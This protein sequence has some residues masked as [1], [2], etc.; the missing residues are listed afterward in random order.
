MFIEICPDWFQ[1]FNLAFQI[2]FL[3]VTASI[4]ITGYG[5]YKFFRQEEQLYLS[6][7]WG[8]IALSYIAS[9]ISQTAQLLTGYN[10]LMSATGLAHMYLFLAGITILLFVYLRIK[11]SGVRAVLFVLLLGLMAFFNQSDWSAKMPAFHLLLAVLM[12]FI[13]GQLTK[14]YRKTCSRARLLVTAGFALLTAG[15][16]LLITMHPIFFVLAMTLTLI[17]YVCIAARCFVR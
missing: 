3:L 9:S 11:D 4:A 15:Q 6:L 2:I 7:G 12:F 1:G 5:A 10:T 13:L 16:L 17:G 8:V 14:A